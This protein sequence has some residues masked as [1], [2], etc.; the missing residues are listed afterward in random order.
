MILLLSSNKNFSFQMILL[1]K[2]IKESNTFFIQLIINII[3]K[4]IL[5][6]FIKMISVCFSKKPF[7]GFSLIRIDILFCNFLAKTLI[8]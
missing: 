1:K 5:I 2:T 6:F 8:P 7:I 4:Q 3:A